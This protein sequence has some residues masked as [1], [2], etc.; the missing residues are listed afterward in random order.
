VPSPT[1]HPTGKVLVLTLGGTIAMTSKDERDSGVA[2]ALTG[3]DLVAAVPQLGD[4]AQVVVEDFLQLPGA[5]LRL[6]DITALAERIRDAAG[7][8]FDGVVVTQGTDTLEETSFLTDLYHREPIPLVFTGAMRNPTM[9]GADGPAN[10]LAAVATAAEPAAR[11]RGVLVV[12][13]DTIHAA[14]YVQKTHTTSTG[15]F[16]SP[17]AGPVG[18]LVE[19]TPC[20]AW[21]LPARPGLPLPGHPATVEIVTTGLGSNGILL[22]ALADRIDGLVVAAFGAGHV[23][24]SWCDRLTALAATIPVVLTSRTRAGSV[25]AS[26]YDFPGSERDLLSRG[27][28]SAGRLDPLKARL[29]L[30]ALLAAGTSRDALPKAFAAY[31][32]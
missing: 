23:P 19:G 20:F 1:A 2:P 25:L 32:R 9:P 11:G 12:L 30:Y 14:R 4:V 29:L 26:T 21:D 15:A 8:G 18:R 13:D 22:D 28:I 17:D 7:D 10:L 3:T 16:S 24:S 5:S 31:T 27:L 6:E